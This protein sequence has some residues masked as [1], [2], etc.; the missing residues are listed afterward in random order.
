MLLRRKKLRIVVTTGFFFILLLIVISNGN[1]KVY[2]L[3]RAGRFDNGGRALGVF[4]QENLAFIADGEQGL[5]I[6]DIIEADINFTYQLKGS[7]KATSGIPQDIF[8]I[9]T[10]AY[11][12]NSF[13]GVRILDFSNPKN[14]TT[15][16]KWRDEEFIPFPIPRT[17]IKSDTYDV[18]VQGSLMYVA[19]GEFGF[20]IVNVSDHTNPVKIGEFFDDSM[21]P[22]DE[23]LNPSSRGL[24]ID[25]SY[26]YVADGTD[27]LEILDISDPTNITKVGQAY[28]NSGRARG[29]FYDSN[30]SLVYLADLDDGVEIID[31][32]DPTNP[33][34]IGQF[35][36]ESGQ[37]TA[38]WVHEN[39][40]FIADNI[41]GLELVD[42]SDPTN[43]VEIG[44]FYDDK[45][46]IVG[47]ALDVYCDG[48][49][50]YVAF[51]IQGLEVIIYGQP[52]VSI[53][54]LPMA[55]V[56]VIILIV[57]TWFIRSGSSAYYRDRQ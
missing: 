8:V 22:D 38:V 53:P 56:T 24:V 29:L 35:Y 36:D 43:P 20:K 19:D 9:G 41:D 17:N 54:V 28:D 27:G 57:I 11:L 26:A 52:P 21:H 16:G 32:S 14:I 37:S 4:V 33:V 31:V 5:E 50:A 1:A 40:C 47:S 44:Q 10:Y 13:A 55:F 2:N 48:F 7:W 3:K 45:S 46:A 15:V 39:W 34:E 6:I 42:V 49:V 23:I 51:G 18:V 25:S 30:N 12:A